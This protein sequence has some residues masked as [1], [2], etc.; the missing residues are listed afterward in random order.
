MKLQAVK[1]TRKAKKLKI[2]LNGP[3]GSGK[4]Y[5]SLSIACG[6][7]NGGRV[8]LIDTE[9]GSASLYADKFDFDVIE[10]PTYTV[11]DYQEALNYAAT[12]KYDVVIL[13]SLSHLW[14]ELLEEADR[15]TIKDPR[16]SSFAAW[17]KV[18]PLYNRAVQAIVTCPVHVIATTRAKSEYV[19]DQVERNG[20]TYNVPRKVGLAPIFRQGGEYEFDVV[21]NIDLEHN[22]I[23]EKTRLDFLA[24]RVIS[25]AGEK[26]GAEMKAWLESAPVQ[27]PAP[28]PPAPQVATNGNGHAHKDEIRHGEFPALSL[29]NDTSPFLGDEN[30]VSNYAA[31]KSE[32]SVPVFGYGKLAERKL[33]ID[34]VSPETLRKYLER[35]GTRESAEWRASAEAWLAGT[36]V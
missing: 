15:Q 33:T 22:L 34:R 26:L 19:I 1:A 31:A 3:S 9:R 14:E 36:E 17:K 30:G 16:H 32:E 28:T 23:I 12:N 6:L 11:A 8:L 27:S 5:Q 4:T 18:T 10:L 13:D 2:C 21:G 29:E 7:K 24:D 20:K 35:W 25:K